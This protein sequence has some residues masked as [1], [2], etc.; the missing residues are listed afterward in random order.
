[1][2]IVATLASKATTGGSLTSVASAGLAGVQSVWGYTTHE[3][4]VFLGVG[5]LIVAMI[6]LIIS[7]TIKA[8]DYFDQRNHRRELLEIAK[9]GLMENKKK[10]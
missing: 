1:M 2:N 8:A 7:S 3:W 10:P 5:G 9:R 4:T 6:G